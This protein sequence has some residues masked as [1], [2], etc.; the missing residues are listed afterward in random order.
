MTGSQ[1]QHIKGA[2][3]TTIYIIAVSPNGKMFATGSADKT[4]KI[5]NF[6]TGEVK[7]TLV[8]HSS[9]VSSLAWTPDS[10]RLITGESR[11]GGLGEGGSRWST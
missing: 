2:H 1:L 10:A 6:E 8:G 4:A 7:F 5:W 9:H 3:T 11:G